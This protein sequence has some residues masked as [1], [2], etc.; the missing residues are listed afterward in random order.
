VLHQ[1]W[2]DL[3]YTSQRQGHPTKIQDP[4]FGLCT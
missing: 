1:G 3:Q 2:M 4:H